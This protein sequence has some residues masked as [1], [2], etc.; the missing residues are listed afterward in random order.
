MVV[1]VECTSCGVT[2]NIRN[3]EILQRKMLCP[4]C[5]EPLPLVLDAEEEAYVEAEINADESVEAAVVIGLGAVPTQPPA[6]RFQKAYTPSLSLREHWWH[7]R[8]PLVLLA[9]LLKLLRIPLPGSPEDPAVTS[10]TPFLST[11]RKLAPEIQTVFGP[12]A[13]VLKDEGFRS[14]VIYQIDDPVQNSEYHMMAVPHQSGDAVAWLQRHVW[15][16]PLATTKP[17][18]RCSFVSTFS[19]GT[20]LVTTNT[21]QDTEC[22]PTVDLRRDVNADIKELWDTH[23]ETLATDTRA[24][25]LQRASTRDAAK[26]VV[27]ELHLA[28]NS[29]HVARGVF[30]P[31]STADQA[32]VHAA[33]T[34]QSSTPARTNDRHAAV[35]AAIEKRQNGKSSWLSAIVLL[36]ISA[37]VFLGLGQARWSWKTTWILL[38][39]LLF[40]EAGHYLA[41]K[42]FG[43]RNLKMFFIPLFGA[44][45]TGAH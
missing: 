16:S 42:I 21:K 31:L 37:A 15:R 43:Y 33:F 36:G 17:T 35:M 22:P 14:P 8:N 9:W 41:M 13:M 6:D 2:L 34:Q 11:Y 30:R 40:H 20:F 23:R 7:N 3:R 24:S 39:V 44:A 25:L 28:R 27:E 38:P 10:L 19:D 12:A 32:A 18:L 29:F 45:V 4:Q 1:S 5:R 26:T